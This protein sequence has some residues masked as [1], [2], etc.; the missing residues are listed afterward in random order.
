MAKLDIFT[1]RLVQEAE[2]TIRQIE[3]VDFLGGLEAKAGQEKVEREERGEEQRL[4]DEVPLS[5]DGSI[6]LSISKDGMTARCSLTPPSGDGSPISMD[7]LS[8]KLALKKIT[9]G[10]DWNAIKTIVM[11]CNTERVPMTN[12]VVAR[13]IQPQAEIPAHIVVEPDLLK[14]PME[15]TEA[16]KTVDHKTRSPY[17]MVTKGTILARVVPKKDGVFGSTV[18]GTA[19][20]FGKERVSY[21]RHGKGTVFQGTNIIAARDGRFM[22]KSDSFWINEVLNVQGNVDYTTGHIDFPGDVVIAGEAKRGF[23]IRAGGSVYC[24][25]IIDATEI[26]CQGDLQTNQGIIGRK[27]GIVKVGGSLRAKYIENCHVE[28]RG[29]ITVLSGCLNAMLFTLDSFQTG[30]RGMLVGGKL[31]AQNGIVVSQIGT[32]AGPRTE[33]YCGIDYTVQ[34]KLTWIRDRN[35]ELAMKL[36]QVEKKITGGLVE[37]MLTALQEKLKESIHKLNEAAKSLVNDLDKNDA[38]TVVVNGSIVHGSYI[39]I[40]HIPYLVTSTMSH[41][42]F[43]LDKPSGIVVCEK[44]K[45]K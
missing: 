6:S 19:V 3:E 20:S 28:V 15:G 4:Y 16:D 14:D 2:S 5:T 30:I 38:A 27:T 23:N 33:V 1:E 13:G 22:L 41:V 21:P 18:Q 25:H 37:P 36:K 26:V 12:V 43:H 29:S 11:T 17:K 35:I 45:V 40:C 44:L 31:Y 32:E 24:N 7:E 39:E 9:V 34:R 42:R 8:S 10:A